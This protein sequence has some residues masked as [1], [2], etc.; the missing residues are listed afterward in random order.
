M[1]IATLI[2]PTQAGGVARN[3]I[4]ESSLLDVREKE[5]RMDALLLVA[6]LFSGLTDG[7]AS[8]LRIERIEATYGPLWPERAP[9]YY[10][11]DKV[12]LRFVIV[13]ASTDSQGNIQTEVTVA[14][15]DSRG[16]EVR[17]KS[18]GEETTQVGV[19]QN[20]CF[21]WFTL[22]LDE[23]IQPG[24]YIV[25]AT[26]TQI[27][28]GATASFERRLTVLEHD[29]SFR[30]IG[31]YADKECTIELASAVRA[32]TA[33]YYKVGLWGFDKSKGKVDVTVSQTV[34]DEREKRKLFQGITKREYHDDRGA[35][36]T[37]RVGVSQGR[38]PTR[39]P[40]R[41]LLK[42]AAT[43]NIAGKS[44]TIEVPFSVSLP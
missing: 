25:S 1:A 32:G 11:G 40:G 2:A 10:P 14:L 31:F 43:D 41:Y 16:R 30:A 35:V 23:D 4:K 24:D 37:M 12:T 28:N 38:I 6:T 27:K 26:V 20:R 22:V 21:R 36:A 17:R 7:A 29:L 34:L 42:I 8:G 3:A 19:G 18:F 13:G 39:C 44:T 15:K 33:L 9:R 5:I